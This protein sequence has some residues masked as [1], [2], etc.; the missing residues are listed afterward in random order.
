MAPWAL[1]RLHPWLA[2]IVLH[3]LLAPQGFVRRTEH[4]R[5]QLASISRA[6]H[7]GYLTKR[8]R[9]FLWAWAN[10]TIPP[11]ALTGLDRVSRGRSATSP[12]SRRPRCEGRGRKPSRF[13]PSPGASWMR[14]ASSSPRTGM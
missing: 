4:V 3:R 7:D 6:L 8:E 11:A 2:T 5:L 9:T 12:C 1:L 10:E 13:L 14:R